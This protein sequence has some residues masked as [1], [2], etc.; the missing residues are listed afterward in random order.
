MKIKYSLIIHFTSLRT[1]FL[2]SFAIIHYIKIIQ[3]YKYR[4]KVIKPSSIQVTCKSSSLFVYD[5]Y[6]QR[7]ILYCEL[8][9][10]S[11]SQL[12]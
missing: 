2:L 7:V 3:D 8:R 6:F 11:D 1:H 4:M 10:T 9:I 12:Y 5:T